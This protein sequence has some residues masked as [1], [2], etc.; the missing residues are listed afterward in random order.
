MD[1]HSV[2]LHFPYCE[3][4]TYHTNMLA[5][6]VHFIS[7]LSF[8]TSSYCIKNHWYRTRTEFSH[9]L[10]QNL[11]YGS[12]S[13]KYVTQTASKWND[14]RI[15]IAV[16]LIILRRRRPWFTETFCKY[17]P[18]LISNILSPNF[19]EGEYQESPSRRTDSL[20]L[21][22]P[23]QSRSSACLSLLLSSTCPFVCPLCLPPRALFLL[24]CLHVCLSLLLL[25]CFSYLS[26]SS[27]SLY[28]FPWQIPL[29]S[30]QVCL[31]LNNAL[32]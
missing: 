30:P 12:P 28:P 20:D 3:F 4:F 32:L 27:V 8:H 10:W 6:H 14:Y 25:I 13:P 21:F 24:L 16:H 31:C 19:G 23:F 11:H 2:T 18:F 26:I 1:Y 22:L 29:A 17:M 5:L 7:C 15:L 9:S